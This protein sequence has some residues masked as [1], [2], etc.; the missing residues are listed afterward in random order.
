MKVLAASA[1]L[2]LSNNIAS[3]VKGFFLLFSFS[4]EEEYEEL[5]DEYDFDLF[6]LPF[7]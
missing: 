2:F 4:S 3:F 7:F 6:F 1:S 5:D